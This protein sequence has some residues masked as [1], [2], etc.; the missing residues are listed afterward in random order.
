MVVH[1]TPKFQRLMAQ[2]EKLFTFGP[3]TSASFKDVLV[4]RFWD[5]QP[6]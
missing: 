5:V 3:R 1:P 6:T 4:R 2:L